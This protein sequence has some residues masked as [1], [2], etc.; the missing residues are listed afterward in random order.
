MNGAMQDSLASRR[1]FMHPPHATI[2]IAAGT[3]AWQ[4]CREIGRGAAE[5]SLQARPRH[6]CLLTSA[7]RGPPHL[8]ARVLDDHLRQ[9]AAGGAAFSVE[10]LRPATLEL[11][12]CD[13]LV[14]L[15]GE[16]NLEDWQSRCIRRY[17]HSG[18]AVVVLDAAGLAFPGWP[19]LARQ[20]TGG[21]CGPPRRVQSCQVVPV[22]AARHHPILAG[23]AP[24]CCRTAL[25]GGVQLA[26]DATLLLMGHGGGRTVP[27]AWTCQD[28]G[29]V[30]ATTLGA[31]DKCLQNGF[32]RLLVQ[33]IAWACDE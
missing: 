32:L 14:L 13:C 10:H 12:H 17:G 4:A 11:D 31:G 1:F 26:A 23:V 19:E 6:V 29:R 3:A 15:P 25:A 22:A 33:A 2:G 24:F 27:V 7:E 20:L 9:G 30:F 16:M 21:R 5:E 18:G 28:P 8:L